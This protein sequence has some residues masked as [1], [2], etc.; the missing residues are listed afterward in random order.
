MANTSLPF[1]ESLQVDSSSLPGP[2][3]A[4]HPSHAF[5]VCRQSSL[6]LFWTPRVYGMPPLSFWTV[7]KEV[8]GPE[9]V[10]TNWMCSCH[11]AASRL[12]FHF[13]VLIPCN[14]PFC[15]RSQVMQ[16]TLQKMAM[17]GQL[18]DAP[19]HLFI[20]IGGK[21]RILATIA[22]SSELLAPWRGSS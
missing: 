14:L 16:K 15:S 5:L 22:A 2:P 12:S 4:I 11:Q 3:A 19:S 7:Q 17:L 10:V 13:V 8:G 18:Q 6:T 9:G 1:K 20:W 21:W